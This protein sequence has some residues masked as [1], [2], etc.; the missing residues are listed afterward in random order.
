MTGIGKKLADF[1]AKNFRV[2]QRLHD[3]PHAIAGGVCIGILFS[4]TPLFGIRAILAVA[5][6]WLLKCSKVAAAIAVNLHELIFFLWPLVY[7]QEYRIGYWLLSTPHHFPPKILH[8]AVNPELLHWSYL[9]DHMDEVQT[10]G[11]PWLFG[12]L[13][14]GIP[15]SVAA[16]FVTLHLVAAYQ[17]KH[18]EK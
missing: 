13:V 11:G 3:T 8:K 12:S 5:I 9:R 7:R 4:F 18:P 10:I 2:L 15:T 16:F 6:A 1:V 14:I 17:R